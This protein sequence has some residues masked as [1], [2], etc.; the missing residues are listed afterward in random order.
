M[1]MVAYISYL[2]FIYQFIKVKWFLHKV[3]LLLSLIKSLYVEIQHV[4]IATLYTL[5]YLHILESTYNFN[6][7]R[8]VELKDESNISIDSWMSGFMMWEKQKAFLSI[9]FW[10]IEDMKLLPKS[11]V[12][13]TQLNACEFLQFKIYFMRP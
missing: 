13:F 10:Y 5:I 1:N 2:Y 12:Q 9:F 3:N 4:T 11:Y 7:L 8:I 6:L